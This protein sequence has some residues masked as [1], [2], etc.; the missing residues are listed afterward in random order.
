VESAHELGELMAAMV[1]GSSASMSTVERRGGEM[2]GEASGGKR[3][4]LEG[5]VTRPVDLTPAY[6]H[7]DASMQCRR[8]ATG[9]PIPPSIFSLN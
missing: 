8:P 1:L 2:E 7:H 9:R 3:G 6:G 5:A 4:G